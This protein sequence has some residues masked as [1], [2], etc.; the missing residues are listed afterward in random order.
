MYKS[1]IPTIIAFEGWDAAGKGG[2]ILR[3]TSSLNPRGYQVVPVGA[4]KEEE[5]THHHLWRFIRRFPK[6]GHI[7]IFD[8]TW[9]GRVLVER[10]ENLTPEEE[11]S[12]AYGEINDMEEMLADHGALLIKFWLQIDKR[13]QLRRFHLRQEDPQ[14]NWKITSEDWRNREKW[15]NY[16]PAIEEMVERTST[17][18]AP[19][20]IV[21]SNDKRFARLYVLQKVIEAMEESLEEESTVWPDCLSQVSEPA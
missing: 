2:N 7:T 18:N 16:M 19:W 1:R 17:D 13:E 14:K 6:D 9:Y 8:R 11:W 5:K 4:P 10:V 20:T 12:L 15:E 21:P 3:L